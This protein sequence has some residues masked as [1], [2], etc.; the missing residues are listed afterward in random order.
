[1]KQTEAD[2]IFAQ[3][4]AAALRPHIER[5]RE[6]GKSLGRIAESLGVTAPGLVKQLSGGTPSVRTVALAFELYGVSVPYVS[7]TVTKAIGQRGRKKRSAENQLVLP[8]EITAPPFSQGIALKLLPRGVRKY[9]L[10]VSFR[11]TR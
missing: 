2:R 6:R 10:Q 11:N 8:F 9:H 3:R 7:I 5:E 1:M 4:F